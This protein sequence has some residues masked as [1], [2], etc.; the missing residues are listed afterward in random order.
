MALKTSEEYVERLK[1]MRPNVYAHGKK[2]GRDDPILQLP[3]NTLR[4][5]FDAVDD[6]ELKDF[7]ITTSHLTGEAINRFTSLNLSIQDLYTQQEMK[8]RCCHRVGGCTQRCMATDTL[9]AIGVVAKEID[10][11]RGTPYFDHFNEFLRTYQENDLVGSTAMTDMKGDRKA[12]PSQQEDP[13]LYLHVVEKRSDGIVVRGAKNHITMGPY[14]DEHLVIPTRSLTKDESDWA[15]SFAIPADTDGIK[16]VSRIVT[17][18]PRIDLKA[19]YNNF[20]VADS[21]VIFDDVFVPWERVF[22]CGEWE[23]AGRL[24]LTFAGFHRHSYCGCKPA[25]TDIILGA[26]ALVAEYNGV[27]NSSHIVDEL[28]ELMIIGELV[29]ASGIAAAAKAT[30][31]SSGIYTP[32]FIYSNTGRYLAGINIYH[33][34]D[35]LASIA[36]GLPST[37]PTEADWL[38]PEIG[39]DLDKY[40]S[41]K[42]GIPA[43]KLHRLYR[44][45]SD[46][47]CSAMCGWAQYAG[48]HGGGS[49]IMEKIGIRSEYDLE[50]KKKI[51]KNLAGIVDEE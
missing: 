23:F 36:G 40:I 34:Y 22:M 33:E 30:K 29:Y 28:T 8:R 26:T 42:P 20:G 46:F 49:P 45:I 47:S 25:L 43:E 10:D 17:P 37:L 35:T 6:P 9:N 11:D 41:R 44:F 51:A 4:F 21:V 13:D 24:A 5:T 39:A 16:I 31:S 12:R 27:G 1:S 7:L 32:K 3:I 18:R 38:N 48:V 14:V 2:I 50:S 19:P 15:V